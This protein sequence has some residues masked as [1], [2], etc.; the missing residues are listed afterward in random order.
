MLASTPHQD[1]TMPHIYLH[2][3]TGYLFTQYRDGTIL[4]FENLKETRELIRTS[5]NLEK[6]CSVKYIPKENAILTPKGWITLP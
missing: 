2:K 4:F 3:K 1:V 6:D 5:P